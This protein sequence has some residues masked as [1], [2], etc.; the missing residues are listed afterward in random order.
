M[1]SSV[2]AKMKM[3]G[4]LLVIRNTYIP[5]CLLV[6]I[7]IFFKHGCFIFQWLP[8]GTEYFNHKPKK[9]IQFL[10]EHG[11]VKSQLDPNEIAIFLRENPGLNKAMIGEYISSRNNLAIL[12]AFVK[13]FEFTDVRIDEALRSFLETFRLPG[14]APTISLIMENFAEHWHVSCWHQSSILLLYI[15]REQFNSIPLVR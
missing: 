7:C 4:F 14:E 15:L 10:Q 9:G 1:N 3:K 2:F 8:Q 12:N 11:V 5:Q 13:T 6:Y